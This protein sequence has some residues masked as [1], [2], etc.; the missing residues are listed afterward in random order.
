MSDKQNKNG[1]I[2][3]QVVVI[4]LLILNTIAVS[5]IMLFGNINIDFWSDNTT[6]ETFNNNWEKVQM[7]VIW[8]ERCTEC[9]TEE[10]TKQILN[11]VNSQ[12]E[13]VDSIVL[14][15]SEEKAK[16][17][18]S[19]SWLTKL[20][21]FLFTSNN[22]NEKINQY[23]VETDD[24]SLFN[25][26]IGSSF[27]PYGEICGNE[28][29]DD[30]NG[31]TDCEDS[32]CGKELSCQPKVDRPVADL[33]IMSHCPY[34]LQAQKWYLEVMSKLGWVADVNVKW[35]PYIMHGQSEADDNVTQ[36]CIQRE[37]KDKY[38]AYL[39]CYLEWEGKD[40]ECRKQAWLDEPK[41]ETCIANLKAEY[42]VDENMADTSR[43]YPLFSIDEETA[44]AAWVQG[45]PS[46]VLN[47]TLVEW[48]GRSAEWYA[49]AICG[50]FKETPEECNQD[51]QDITFDPN[52]GFTTGNWA[53]SA[54]SGCGV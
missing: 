15:F 8:D 32:V 3:F 7:I 5:M 24:K 17:Y 20:P 53:A 49:D 25:L 39:S 35:V 19:K 45:S 44:I 1:G 10:I 51:F 30:D 50:M 37:Q 38:T 21:V 27:D 33:Y 54:D 16:Q 28:I 42:K 18:L 14:D 52:Y 11:D 9:Y 26:E 23:L 47:G 29:D 22:F 48:I 41:L 2:I 43:Q 4:L 13:T 40:L 31:L 12:W 46:F 34:W 36:E 6:K